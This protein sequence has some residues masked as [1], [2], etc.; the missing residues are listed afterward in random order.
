ML[1]LVKMYTSRSHVLNYELYKVLEMKIDELRSTVGGVEDINELHTENKRLWSMLVVFKD[2]RAKAEYKID[3]ARTIQMMS[4]KARKQAE[5]KLKI[6][7]DMA[8]AKHPI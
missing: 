7:E 1:K 2:A 4:D 8:H 5:L 3:M 6:C